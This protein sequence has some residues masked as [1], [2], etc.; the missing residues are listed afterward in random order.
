[1]YK[2]TKKQIIL[3]STILFISN[4]LIFVQVI[5]AEGGNNPSTAPTYAPGEYPNE[6]FTTSGESYYNVSGKIG[7]NL[8]AIVF[9]TTT[10]PNLIISSPNGTHLG[11]ATTIALNT[12]K[13]SVICDSNKL[14]TI[15]VGDPD[16]G[17][18]K[19]YGNFTLTIILYEESTDSI[20]GFCLAPILISILMIA[21]IIIKIKTKKDL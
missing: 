4:L 2:L 13:I 11:L 5:N 14:Y 21:A 18:L 17:V 1:M 7:A 6:E 20:P 8:T 3:I 16:A 15:Q 19:G 10:D 12:Q 9:C